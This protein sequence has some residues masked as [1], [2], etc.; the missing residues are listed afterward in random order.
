MSSSKNQKIIVVLGATAAQG[1]G[2]VSALLK[3]SQENWHIRGVTT[4]ASAPWAE[5][6]RAKYDDAAPGR[7][8][9]VSGD[10]YDTESLK[11]AF[12]GAYGIFA[13]TSELKSKDGQPPTEGSRHEVEQGK[14]IVDVAK[15][16]GLKH[17]VMSTLPDMAKAS[18]GRYTGMHHMDHKFEVEQYAK[19]QLDCVTGVIPGYFYSNHHWPQY[20]QLRADGIVRFCCPVPAA[21]W[22]DPAYDVGV[23]AARIFSLGKDKTAGKDYPVMAPRVNMTDMAATFTRITGRKAIYDPIS[24]DE[25]ADLTASM[26]GPAFREDTKQMMEWVAQIPEDKIVYG[27]LDP[28]ED[29][30]EKELGVRA[31]TFEEWIKRTAWKGPTEV[32]HEEAH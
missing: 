22:V 6:F 27:A 9:L 10:V 14:N 12:S 30:S 15:Q 32:Y 29:T 1:N 7:V 2:V 8:S 11:A 26:I 19:S 25:W 18:S 21:E 24:V 4:D 20:C 13:M 16:C 5:Q 31:S 23:F 3:D 17:F 28:E